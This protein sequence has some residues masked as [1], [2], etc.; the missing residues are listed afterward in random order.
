MDL[1]QLLD[2]YGIAI[3]LLAAIGIALK[4]GVWPFL[5]EQVKRFQDTRD[6]ERAAFIASL[7]ALEQT[8]VA[9]KP[10]EIQMYVDGL[11]SFADKAKRGEV[12]RPVESPES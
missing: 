5:V 3:A 12:D 9:I 8:A 4:R 1:T 10:K 11:L 6:Q 2:R 7:T